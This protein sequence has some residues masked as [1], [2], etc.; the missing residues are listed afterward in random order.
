[1]P[2]NSTSTT[3]ATRTMTAISKPLK[4]IWLSLRSWPCEPFPRSRLHQRLKCVSGALQSGDE[5]LFVGLHSPVEGEQPC[6]RVGEPLDRSRN[7]FGSD[8]RE[9]DAV[10]AVTHDRMDPRVPGDGADIGQ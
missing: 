6:I 9:G 1:M 4:S 5:G 2:L 3:S 8:A 10:A 7:N